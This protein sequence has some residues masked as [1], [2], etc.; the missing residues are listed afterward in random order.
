MRPRTRDQHL[1]T[2]DRRGRR[3]DACPA[4]CWSAGRT[5]AR[6]ACLTP[7][8]HEAALGRQPAGH[9]ARLS[10]G[11]IELD[12]VACRLVDTAGLDALPTGPPGIA[13]RTNCSRGQR[14]A[15]AQAAQ[16][17]SCSC[18]S[19]APAPLNDWERGFWR[20]TGPAAHSSCGPSAMHRRPCRSPSPD[21]RNQCATRGSAWTR[22][23]RH[24]AAAV[25][26]DAWRSGRPSHGRPLRPTACK[27]PAS[28]S[29]IAAA[30][31][32]SGARRGADRQR[33]APG[34]R[35]A[36]PRRRRRL[37]RRHP[38]ASLQPLLHRQIA[39]TR[40]PAVGYRSTTG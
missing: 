16:A 1:H 15:A 11:R 4:P 37:H 20:R 26:L 27:P 14:L 36:G 23:G 33:T 2:T 29:C 28:R 35:R 7:W 25:E 18:A 10:D 12:G 39:E 40:P 21:D 38:G 32:D 8:R 13:R 9:D 24:R 17:K 5:S 19:T 30:L 34:T 22:C 3:D 6:A 31:N